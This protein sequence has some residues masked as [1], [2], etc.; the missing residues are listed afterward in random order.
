MKKN[1]VKGSVS[2]LGGIIVEKG[3]NI[4][5]KIIGKDGIEIEIIAYH[6]GKN[7]QIFRNGKI[8]IVEDQSDKRLVKLIKRGLAEIC[9]ALVYSYSQISSP[10]CPGKLD[11]DITHIFNT[12]PEFFKRGFRAANSHRMVPF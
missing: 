9:R 12:L 6:D 10:S 1:S 4:Q 11:K 3:K 5:K 7:I 8:I 2:Y